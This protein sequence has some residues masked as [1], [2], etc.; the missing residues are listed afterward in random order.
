[1]RPIVRQSVRLANRSR[2]QSRSNHPRCAQ[3][4]IRSFSKSVL[5][6]SDNRPPT[7]PPEQ[8]TPF[9]FREEGQ[10]PRGDVA[11]SDTKQGAQSEA[12]IAEDEQKQRTGLT[13]RQRRREALTPTVPKPPPIPEW[14]LTHNVKLHVERA[15]SDRQ[16]ES[17]QVL[18][19]ADNAT[20]HVLFTL[21]YYEAWPVPDLKGRTSSGGE[22]NDGELAQQKLSEQSFFDSHRGD[23]NGTP[24]QTSSNTR[25]Q[26][27]KT[28]PSDEAYKDVNPHAL[29]RWAILQAE[30]G[31]RAAFA[32]AKDVPQHSSQAASRVDLTL[33]CRDSGSDSHL[34]DLVEDL[35]AI[36]GSDIIRLDAN[37]LAEL[38]ADYVGRGSDTPGSFSNLAYDVFCNKFAPSSGRPDRIAED[39][40]EDDLEED[41]ADEDEMNDSQGGWGGR[42]TKV[43]ALGFTSLSSLQRRLMDAAT[44]VRKSPA[45]LEVDINVPMERSA[46]HREHFTAMPSSDEPKYDDAKLSALLDDL[47]DA[48]ALKRRAPHTQSNETLRRLG[49]RTAG[50]YAQSDNAMWRMWRS[51]TGSWLPDVSGL[52][53]AHVHAS[54]DETGKGLSGVKLEPSEHCYSAEA[55]AGS[56][57]PKTIIHIRNLREICHNRLGEAIIRCLVSIT[58]KRRRAGSEVV[59]VGTSSAEGFPFISHTPG[60][61]DFREVRVPAVFELSKEDQALYKSSTDETWAAGPKN[62]R[63][64]EMNLRHIRRMLETLQPGSDF[65]PYSE[66]AQRLLVLGGY[67]LDREPLSFDRVQALV[68]TAIGLAQSHALSSSV[69]ASHIALASHIEWQAAKTASDSF[70]NKNMRRMARFQLSSDLNGVPEGDPNSVEGGQSRL[71]KLKQSSNSH[72]TRLFPSVIDPQNIKT[73]FDQVHAPP[74]TIDAL[75]MLTSLSLQRP[76]AFKYGILA[77]DRLPGLLLYGPPGTGKTLLAKA[78]AKES[79]ATVLEISGAQIYEKYVGEGEKMVRAV[80]S[81]AKKLTPCILF[82][83]E[84]DAIFGS[85]SNAGNRNTHR[86]IINQFL[87]EWDGM[88]MHNVFVMVASNRPFDLDDAVLRR[89]PRRLLVDLPVAKDRESILKIHLNDETLDESVDL[90]KLAGDTP[91]Y[92][93]SDLKNLCVSAALACVGEENDLAQSKKDDKEFKLPE[94]RVLSGRH[95]EKAIKEISASIS[96]DMDSLTAIK[97]FDEQ[98]GD[99]RG[100]KT[101]PSYG[102]GQECALELRHGSLTLAAGKDYLRPYFSPPEDGLDS[103]W[104]MFC[105]ALTSSHVFTNSWSSDT[106]FVSVS[107]H[108]HSE[109]AALELIM[110]GGIV[111]DHVIC[112]ISRFMLS[113]FEAKVEREKQDFVSEKQSGRKVNDL[114]GEEYA[115]ECLGLLGYPH[116]SFS[117]RCAGAS[118]T[119]V[120]PMQ[121]CFA[122]G[123]V[124]AVYCSSRWS[125]VVLPSPQEQL[126]PGRHT[127]PPPANEGAGISARPGAFSEQ[128]VVAAERLLISCLL[129]YTTTTAVSACCLRSLTTRHSL[130]LFGT[131]TTL[132]PVETLI[133]RRSIPYRTRGPIETLLLRMRAATPTP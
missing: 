58:Q 20:G 120:T 98:F 99:R 53:A 32:T 118:R 12:K 4:H 28:P 16:A 67:D 115:I 88:E 119:E 101:R 40:G 49:S 63:F 74:E 128:I 92:S 29:L 73:G 81:L 122:P 103:V 30:M 18:K 95:F 50:P 112:V 45:R 1:M 13:K 85:R 130:C 78:V 5:Y 25:H 86:E 15:K 129:L 39:E 89:L 114:A 60:L 126:L 123:R 6:Q 19:C 57:P 38:T 42:W 65:D 117:S 7:L 76:D 100:R 22:A 48:P 68:L 47:L 82:L 35:A 132:F 3:Q 131:T 90:A 110:F 102:F 31:I 51:D 108:S 116:V 97:K 70:D 9:Q 33:H 93:G 83:D 71:D 96:E 37:D 2:S 21:P 56:G 17:A 127:T 62:P 109:M 80:F 14:F 46:M 79:G 106:N 94:K 11:Q 36:T 26:P 104:Q 87:R 27:I 54:S 10:R 44:G 55:P 72:E 133:G 41:E 43:D 121:R 66:S 77:A 124:G 64:L 8:H 24:D 91:L 125:D 34:D 23:G 69:N 59:L 105:C 52:L 107:R 113:L 84:A 111:L 75:K 61:N